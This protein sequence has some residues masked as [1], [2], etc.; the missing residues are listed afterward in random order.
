MEMDNRIVSAGFNPLSVFV[1]IV[2]NIK[3]E[4]TWYVFHST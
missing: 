4:S 3:S 1:L 2:E